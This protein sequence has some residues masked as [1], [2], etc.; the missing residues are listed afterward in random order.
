MCRWAC[1]QQ[2]PDPSHAEHHDH[3]I[4]LTRQD[5]GPA[6]MQG[7]TVAMLKKKN[8]SLC[9]QKEIPSQA[10]C[11]DVH[12]PPPLSTIHQPSIHFSLCFCQ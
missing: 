7:I 4:F 1:Q 6:G 10:S 5:F 2:K 12:I 9:F 8:K 11:I 3:A